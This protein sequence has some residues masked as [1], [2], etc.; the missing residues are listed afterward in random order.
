MNNYTIEIRNELISLSEEN[1]QVF[2]ASLIPKCN[3]II[4]VRIPI[5]RKLAK[6]IIKEEPIKYLDEDDEIYFE[7]TMLKGL[8]I[9]NIEINIDELINQI[10][11]FIPKITNWSLCDSFCN[12]LKVVKQHKE[13]FYNYIKKYYKSN[14]PY[15]IRFAVVI[16]LFYYIEKDYLKDIF[17]I[18]NSI[19][20]DD[21][22][23]QMAIAW[24]ISMCYVKYPIE[25]M[26]YL[27]DNKLDKFTYNKSLQKIIESLKVSKED[28]ERI[29]LMK[30]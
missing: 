16:L 17:K 11:L 14:E 27:K 9:G 18:M 30:I 12:E 25:T 10:T 6:R 3:N 2:S 4:G 5:I 21:Y 7:E 19:K 20:N 23:V 29:K 15:E 22:Y 8:I 13:L 24:C 28:K 1:F 26:E